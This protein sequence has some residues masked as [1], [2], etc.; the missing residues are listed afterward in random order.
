MKKNI[1]VVEDSLTILE[2]LSFSLEK[3][4]YNVL[5]AN[6][7][8]DALKFFDGRQIDLLITDLYMPKMTGLELVKAIKQINEYNNIP[9]LFLT[10]ESQQSKKIEAKKLGVTGWVIKPFVPEKLVSA[11]NKLL[12]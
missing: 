5:T 12:N 1:V 2:V 4:N 3:A 8:N 6:C 7:G 11:I 10:T 9:I